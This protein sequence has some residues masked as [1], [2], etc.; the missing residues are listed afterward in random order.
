MITVNDVKAE[1]GI[2]LIETEV[3][4]GKLGYRN[5][6]TEINFVDRTINLTCDGR[7]RASNEDN[8]NTATNG[9]CLSVL[10]GIE[11]SS[12]GGKNLVTA[13]NMLANIG[14]EHKVNKGRSLLRLMQLP[15][16]EQ[17]IQSDLPEPFLKTVWKPLN[18]ADSYYS[19]ASS[20]SLKRFSSNMFVKQGN[21][22]NI[23]ALPKAIL[24][25]LVNNNVLDLRSLLT[26]TDEELLLEIQ[27]IKEDSVYYSKSLDVIYTSSLA[28][29][30][31]DAVER[32]TRYYTQNLLDTPLDK[33]K[34][35]MMVVDKFAERINNLAIHSYNENS[36]KLFTLLK[37]NNE[38]ACDNFVN[39]AIE[40]IAFVALSTVKSVQLHRLF[41]GDT[42]KQFIAIAKQAHTYARTQSLNAR[43]ALIAN[44]NKYNEPYYSFK[45]KKSIATMMLY[46]YTD[47]LT[48][49][50]FQLTE[51]AF[52]QGEGIN[53]LTRVLDHSTT[54]PYPYSYVIY[55]VFHSLETKLENVYSNT[56]KEAVNLIETV[57]TILNMSDADLLDS[58]TMDLVKKSSSTLSLAVS[59]AMRAHNLLEES[60]NPLQNMTAFI[61]TK[62]STVYGIDTISRAI[63]GNY[64]RI[65]EYLFFSLRLE[66]GVS[67]PV[68]G[69]F[70]TYS[71][72]IIMSSQVADTFEK[73]P[74][75]LATKHDIVA[76]NFNMLQLLEPNDNNQEVLTDVVKQRG[77]HIPINYSELLL[78]GQEEDGI[79]FVLPKTP[80]EIVEEGNNKGH[81]VASYVPQVVNGTCLIGFIRQKGDDVASHGVTVEIKPNSKGVGTISQARMRFNAAPTGI[82]D[83][84]LVKLKQYLHKNHIV[85]NY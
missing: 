53:V 6:T 16:L 57:N 1:K 63:H 61:N 20:S 42:E 38:T 22:G 33:L 40:I 78:D 37:Q 45:E 84:S 73:Y 59:Y 23:F 34:E 31:S 7:T 21:I 80:R 41:S 56:D 71:D 67:V 75:Y 62:E 83:T 82:W 27:D 44:K 36:D 64:N 74:S 47:A 18:N 25:E 76:R 9:L 51:E 4:E 66:Q 69:G 11:S 43:D 19:V 48:N 13:L 85:F 79:Y 26:Q 65:I 50:L 3:Y 52:G 68:S 55:P 77:I 39:Y 28:S 32:Y 72:Y 15:A 8:I 5:W 10:E 2:I 12:K 58:L 30:M 60:T 14:N 70:N 81:C 35:E 54:M 29:A 49:E 17:I 24:K 46:V